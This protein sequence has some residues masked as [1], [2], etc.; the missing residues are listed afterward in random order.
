MGLASE[1]GWFLD[2]PLGSGLETRCV[3]HPCG[4][5]SVRQCPSPEFCVWGDS[6][7]IN[8]SA[9]SRSIFTAALDLGTLSLPLLHPQLSS[10]SSVSLSLEISPQIVSK[11]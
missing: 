9:R 7:F 6:C 4:W 2:S 5:S 3:L 1:S 8:G 11:A 10:H